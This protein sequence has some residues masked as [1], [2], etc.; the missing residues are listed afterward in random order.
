MPPVLSY[1]IDRV[2][3]R[4]FQVESAECRRSAQSELRWPDCDY[5]SF[6]FG[7]P[8]LG[9]AAYFT[10][11]QPLS[12]RAFNTSNTQIGS[13]FS[14]FSNN[15]G[16]AGDLGSSPNELFQVSS[17][18]G[19]SSVSIMGDPA[20]GSFVMDDVGLTAA[21]PEPAGLWLTAMALSAL[22]VRRRF[23]I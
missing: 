1:R 16:T 18:G 20:G 13:A 2:R 4:T 10:Y 12:L 14:L 22:F 23:T 11:L 6:A 5:E 17:P 3:Q 8:V 19:I 7:T 15:T 21:V 9:F